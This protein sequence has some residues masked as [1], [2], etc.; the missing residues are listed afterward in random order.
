MSLKQVQAI[1][2]T[3]YAAANQLVQR[4]VE[5]GVLRE[6]AGHARDRRFRFDEY[7]AL[8]AH[9]SMGSEGSETRRPRTA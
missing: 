6:I 5:L 4:L 3:S 8:F 9:D 1:T 7:V 2:G